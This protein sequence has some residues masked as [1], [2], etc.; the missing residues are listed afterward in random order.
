ML[1]KAI[2]GKIIADDSRYED[3]SMSWND[4]YS[5]H[6]KRPGAEEDRLIASGS[7]SE[8]VRQFR[9]LPESQRSQYSM[10]QGGMRWNY[11]EIDTIRDD[12]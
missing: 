8:M 9:N 7:K 12:G 3:L 10:M 2:C 4:N 6:R 11:L 5:L 1:V